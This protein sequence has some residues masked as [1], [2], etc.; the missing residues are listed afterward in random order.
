MQKQQNKFIRL[1]LIVLA[2][3]FV[4]VLLMFPGEYIGYGEQAAQ[5]G[6]SLDV[7]ST[8]FFGIGC[9]LV[10]LTLLFFRHHWS[11]EESAFLGLGIMMTALIM[12]WG[13][14]TTHEQVTRISACVVF[15]VLVCLWI[16]S[17]RMRPE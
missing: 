7:L 1:A 10:T 15:V 5:D 16:G 12:N 6:I 9:I 3:V 8:I 17:Q 14:M 2:Y 13:E 11:F 4:N